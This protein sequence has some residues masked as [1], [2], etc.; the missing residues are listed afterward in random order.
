MDEEGMGTWDHVGRQRMW[1]GLIRHAVTLISVLLF[2]FL[3]LKP[4]VRWLTGRHST[5]EM[6]PAL[7]RGVAG[8]EA[9]I[10][11]LAFEGPAESSSHQ[12]L[13]ELANADKER[14]ARMVESWLK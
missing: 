10:P 9:G 13:I 11:R 4:M 8:D 3:I 12:R 1:S 14:F 6:Q 7:P 5:N 2:L